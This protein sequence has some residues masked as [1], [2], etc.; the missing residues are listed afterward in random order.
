M[1]VE[2]HVGRITQWQ[3]HL[4][5]LEESPSPSLEAS[6]D[7]DDDGDFDYNDDDED[8]DARSSRDDTMTT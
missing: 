4:G 8:E 2:H 5:G 6:E 3:A 1:S 7:E